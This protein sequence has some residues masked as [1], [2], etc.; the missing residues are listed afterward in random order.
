MSAKTKLI[1]AL[2]FLGV[3]PHII[4]GLLTHSIVSHTISVESFDQGALLERLDL[5][6]F[7]FITAGIFGFAILGLVISRSITTPLK[8]MLALVGASVPDD[9]MQ[10]VES[11]GSTDE[12]GLL[13]KTIST[14]FERLNQREKELNETNLKLEENNKLLIGQGHTLSAHN[15]LLY[16]IL[17][18]SSLS[19]LGEGFL[20]KFSEYRPSLAGAVYLYDSESREITELAAKGINSDASTLAGVKGLM[21]ELEKTKKSLLFRRNDFKSEF[22][23]LYSASDPAFSGELICAPVVGSDIKVKGAMLFWGEAFSEPDIEFANFASFVLGMGLDKVEAEKKLKQMATD[24]RIKGEMLLQK[25]DELLEI[26]RLRSE[27]ISLVSHELRTPLNSIIG[28]SEILLDSIAGELLDRQKECVQDILGSGLHLLQIVNDILDLSKIEAGYLEIEVREFDVKEEVEAAVKTMTPMASKKSQK[29]DVTAGDG[30]GGAV[31]DGGKL[32][33][34]LL[35]LISNGLKFSPENSTVEVSLNKRGAMV[36]IAIKDQGIGIEEK[37]IARLFKP[38]VQADSSHARNYEG[39]GLGLVICKKLVE[40]LGGT[41][42][43][44]S[45]PGEGSTF[46]FT[47]LTESEPGLL[48]GKERVKDNTFFSKLEEEI[49]AG[50]LDSTMPSKLVLVFE[51][52][53]KEATELCRQLKDGGFEVISFNHEKDLLRATGL[54]QP[55]NVTL[56]FLHPGYDGKRLIKR[57]GSEQLMSEI[58]LLV[59]T[60]G[61]PKEN[62]DLFTGQVARIMKIGDTAIKN[63]RFMANG[64]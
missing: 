56:N 17:Q 31:S 24:L 4:S 11:L 48:E 44:D 61:E 3:V 64:N 6:F 12:I 36:E 35:N 39:T 63:I 23:D 40:V 2:L 15:D 43:V 21:G 32:S 13:E 26:D 59:L 55:D 42:W 33:Q 46:F 52:G 45:L 58:P 54:L 29:I 22:A 20:N 47:F 8:K 49:R 19:A 1:I 34:V 50:R 7:G 25:N 27:F 53:H 51:N 5:L 62:E 37:D 28:F 38:F 57:L 41:I 9:V 16:L 10:E 14:V 60:E 30:V 18:S